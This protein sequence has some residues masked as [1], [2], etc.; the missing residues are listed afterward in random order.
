MCDKAAK[1]AGQSNEFPSL[2]FVSLPPTSFE[3]ENG[4]Y[5]LQKINLT[6]EV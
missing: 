1:H 2:L 4:T 6:N 3:T 5:R